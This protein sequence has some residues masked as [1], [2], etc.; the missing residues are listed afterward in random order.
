ME[1]ANVD[2]Y[3]ISALDEVAWVTNLRSSDIPHTPVFRSYML[4]TKDNVTLY[5][6]SPCIRL[7]ES[8]IEEL[9]DGNNSS[10]V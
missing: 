3:L 7:N 4:I 1:N 6:P 5:I 2:L 8:L 10:Y 9:T